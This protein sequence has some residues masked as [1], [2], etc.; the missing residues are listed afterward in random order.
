MRSSEFFQNFN[1]VTILLTGGQFVNLML[2]RYYL[3]MTHN[4]ERIA[5][6][7]VHLARRSVQ[8]SAS[9]LTSAQWAALRFFAHANRFSRQP[10]VFASY[11]GTT[12]GTASQT[13]KTLVNMG[14]LERSRGLSDG[15][16]AVF[17]VTQSGMKAL[18]SDPLRSLVQTLDQLSQ[19][20]R[21]ALCDVLLTINKQ[22]EES[23]MG[24]ED[25][26]FGTCSNC[27]HFRQSGPNSGYC[28]QSSTALDIFE[29]DKLC[30]RFS[31]V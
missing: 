7:L 25:T 17:D 11:H 30:C 2:K 9:E 6:L 8:S 12:R 27:K 10:S 24:L 26:H 13:V 28:S 23:E 16:S 29:T 31:S 3:F 22:S 4:S 15:R 20:K 14:Y 21:E 18:D 19:D 1:V 5:D